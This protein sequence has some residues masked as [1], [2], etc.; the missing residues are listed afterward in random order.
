MDLPFS[1]DDFD[2][3]V[4]RIGSSPHR[5][6]S[7]TEFSVSTLLR[8]LPDQKYTSCRAWATIGIALPSPTHTVQAVLGEQAIQA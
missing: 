8:H 6:H 4:H 1:A 7:Y 5:H 2:S 3:Y